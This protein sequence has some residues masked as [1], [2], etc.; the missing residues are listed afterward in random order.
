LKLQFNV[1]VWNT[2]LGV[3]LAFIFSFIGV[4]ATGTVG[5]NPVGA[6]GKCSQL[7]FGGVTKL[8]GLD[9]KAAQSVNLIAGSLAGQAAHHSVDMTSDLKIGHLLS[10]TPKG[11]FW[12]QMVGTVAGIVPLT[13]L[14]VVYTNAYPCITDHTIEKCPFSMPAVKAWK[15]VA[16]AMTSNEAPIP[17]ASGSSNRPYNC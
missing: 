3:I 13:G 4:Q 11:Q 15:M 12:A 1:S 17:K 16:I 7:V 2:I 14:F 8:E 5:I 6:I 9:L 10:A